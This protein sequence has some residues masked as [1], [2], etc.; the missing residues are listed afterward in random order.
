MAD[1]AKDLR[2]R[3]KCEGCHE[4]RKTEEMFYVDFTIGRMWLCIDPFRKCAE[5]TADVLTDSVH[6][7][8]ESYQI[9]E[10]VKRLALKRKM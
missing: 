6:A 2:H 3:Y 10:E 1:Q 5:K 8:R 7:A 9:S 4:E